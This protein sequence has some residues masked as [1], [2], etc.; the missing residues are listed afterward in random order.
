METLNLVQGSPEWHAH[1]STHFNA[2]D[3]PVMLGLSPYKTRTQLLHEMA[4]GHA[5]EVD[6]AT[7]KRYDYGHKFEAL[8][9]PLAEEFIGQELFPVVGSLGKLSASFDGLTMGE[10]IGF[11]H[12]T[13]NAELR[14][15]MPRDGAGDVALPPLYCAQM[16]QQLM[17]SGAE[18]ILFMAS[19]W[20]GEELIE[21]RHCWYRSDPAMRTRLEQGWAQFE[22]D[23]KAYAPAHIEV[24]PQGRTPETLP[25]LHIE[26]TGMVTASNLA[27]FKAHALEVFAGINTELITDQQFADAEKTVKWCGDVEERLEAAK[28]HALSQTSSIDELFRAIDDIKAEARRVRLDLS[29]KVDAEKVNRR[30]DIQQDGVKRL[31]EHIATL[32]QRL[33]KPFMPASAAVADFAGAMKGKKT[34]S[35]LREAV[36]TTLASAKIAASA[37]ADSIQINMATMVELASEH[38][39]LF[40]DVAQLVLKANDDLRAVIALRISEHEAAEN[41]KADAAKTVAPAA[42]GPVAAAPAPAVA[43]PAVIAMPARVQP[44][45][46]AVPTLRLGVLNE[47]LAPIQLTAD[48]F[49]S[50]GFKGVKDR[51]AVLFHEADFPHICAALVAH[52]QQIQAKQAA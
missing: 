10:D 31:A 44:A 37:I 23:L 3:A 26:V 12:K 50:L 9:R 4:T 6:A 52:V 28:Q 16:E 46:G 51:G 40:P 27:E 20:R 36:A 47:R 5:P 25:A 41:R 33:G 34:M 11:E 2:S 32:N 29:K 1:R 18:R 14:A 39:T 15:C 19:S 7:Q 21:E 45:A 49:A 24:K 13:L 30:N 43:A 22:Q 42:A 38:A 35:S 8:A 17:I 48:G